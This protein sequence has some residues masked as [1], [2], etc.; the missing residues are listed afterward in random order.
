MVIDVKNLNHQYKIFKKEEGFIGG[1]IDFFKRKYFYAD[2]VKDFN[3][4]IK[5]PQIL[6]FLG[7]NGA[8]KTTTLKILSGLIKPT[9]G[10]VRV[11]GF[12]PYE[13]K[14]EFKNKIGFLMGNKS[15]LIFD[16]PPV[17]TFNMHRIIY[18][19]PGHQ[20]RERMEYL[21]NLFN[22]EEKLNIPV[23]KLSLGERMKM[24]FIASIIHGP[25]VIFLDEPTL[26]MDIEAQHAFRGFIQKYYDKHKITFIITSHNMNDIESLCHRLVIIQKGI[27]VYDNP[28]DELKKKFYRKKVI[29]ELMESPGETDLLKGFTQR[30]ELVYEKIMSENNGIFEN[31]STLLSRL[32]IK[33]I[34]IQDEH[35]ES[36]VRRLFK[37]GEEK[38]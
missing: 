5:G 30:S 32:K 26:G 17:E 11:L 7:P 18:G 37:A 19:I 21:L 28:M 16:L 29:I 4:E 8:G 9:S 1:V 12:D 27:K 3:L 33:D 31:F 38:E 14:N 10:E 36:V 20:Y 6:G 2:A 25:Q 34:M 13:R 23:R 15:Q 22:V 24:E 35:L